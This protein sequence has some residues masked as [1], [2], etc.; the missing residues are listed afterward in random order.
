MSSHST[1]CPKHGDYEDPAETGLRSG[2]GT[3]FF[4]RVFLDRGTSCTC[5]E[6]REDEQ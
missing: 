4:S 2:K 3:G 6:N 5:D 1:D